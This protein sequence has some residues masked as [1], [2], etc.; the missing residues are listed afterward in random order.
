MRI[1]RFPCVC[2]GF[3]EALAS[4]LMVNRSAYAIGDEIDARLFSCAYIIHDFALCVNVIRP[5]TNHRLISPRGHIA[6]SRFVHPPQPKPVLSPRRQE[7]Q[8]GRMAVP[9]TF[10]IFP[11]YGTLRRDEGVFARDIISWISVTYD[12]PHGRWAREPLTLGRLVHGS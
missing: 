12:L 11:G 10:A 6:A 2:W 8:E 7:R 9:F 5:E 3:L 4:M 1:I